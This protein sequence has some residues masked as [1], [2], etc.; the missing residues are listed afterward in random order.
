MQN[1]NFKAAVLFKQKQKLRIIKI[2][3][4]KTLLKGQVL[5][6]IMYSGICGS[7]LGEISGVKGKD[8]FL[9]QS[10]LT[11]LFEQYFQD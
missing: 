5:V 11:K 7:Q 3:P 10:Y 9:P 8:N 2:R 6:K 4:Q 1:L